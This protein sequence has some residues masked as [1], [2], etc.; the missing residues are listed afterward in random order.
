MLLRFNQPQRI[1]APIVSISLIQ[2][3]LPPKYLITHVWSIMR[4]GETL[5]AK[6]HLLTAKLDYGTNCSSAQERG[7][8][9]GRQQQIITFTEWPTGTKLGVRQL[10]QMVAQIFLPLQNGKS[11]KIRSGGCS[12]SRRGDSEAWFARGQWCSSLRET[13]FLCTV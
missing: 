11:E 4:G 9:Y 8:N 2:S 7:S 1:S 3:V 10:C 5:V 13:A 6:W 12:V